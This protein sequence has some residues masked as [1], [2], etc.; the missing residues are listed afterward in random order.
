MIREPKSLAIGLGVPAA[1]ILV[2]MPFLADTSV[3]V[4]GIPLLFFWIF[5]LF[6]FTTFC[7]WMA[8]RIDEPSYRNDSGTAGKDL[9]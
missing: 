4:F 1:S 7:L 5:S 2:V 3:H 6:P 9:N 8:W